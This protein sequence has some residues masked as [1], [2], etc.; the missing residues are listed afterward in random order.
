MKNLLKILATFFSVIAFCATLLSVLPLF[1]IQSDTLDPNTI[2]ISFSLI[3][4]IFT[5]VIGLAMGY[6]SFSFRDTAIVHGEKS[7]ERLNKNIIDS[8]NQYLFCIGSRSRDGNYLKRIEAN[9]SDK[10][11]L[12]HYRVLW[13]YPHREVLTDH[14][15]SLTKISSPQKRPQRLH[16]GIFSDYYKEAE[17]CIC[18]N[19]SEAVIILPSLTEVGKYDTALH[20]TKKKTVK[21]IIEYCRELYHSGD[22]LTSIVDIDK[23]KVLRREHKRILLTKLLVKEDA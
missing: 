7:I 10:K 9:F 6:I 3:S 8:A 2:I 4:L 22:E 1:G 21:S 14:L 17:R 20:I 11:D 19:E 12:I 5:I 15:K 18:V 16:I 13:G 23:L